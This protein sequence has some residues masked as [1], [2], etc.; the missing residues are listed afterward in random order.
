VLS[1]RLM[2][3]DDYEIKQE[4]QDGGYLFHFGCLVA[5]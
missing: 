4:A 5:V 3:I 2:T 1:L